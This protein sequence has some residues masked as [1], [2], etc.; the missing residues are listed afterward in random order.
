VAVRLETLKLL[1]AKAVGSKS[2]ALK[3]ISDVAEVSDPP[4]VD[5]NGIKADKESREQQEWH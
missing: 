4:Q 2:R 1:S 3:A 5:R